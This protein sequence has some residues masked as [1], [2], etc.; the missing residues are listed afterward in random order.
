MALLPVSGLRLP[1]SYLDDL[2]R[3]PWHQPPSKMKITSAK[4]AGEYRLEVEFDNGTRGTIDLCDYA[5]IGIFRPWLQP[6]FFKQ[7][8]VSSEGALSWPGGLDLC[9][10]ALY[11]RLTGQSAEE[12]FPALRRNKAKSAAHA[13]VSRA[14]AA[15]ERMRTEGFDRAQVARE[16]EAFLDEFARTGT[17]TKDDSQT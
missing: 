12:I 15:A 17:V 1:V 4:P 13:L 8:S 3:S 6:E 5:G 14:R 9:A 16:V 7:V 10:D 11:L 2:L